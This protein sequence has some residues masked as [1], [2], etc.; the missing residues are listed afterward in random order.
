MIQEIQSPDLVWAYHLSAWPLSLVHGS[1][2]MKPYGF[3]PKNEEAKQYIRSVL[4]SLGVYTP[5]DAKDQLYQW[6]QGKGINHTFQQTVRIID[7]MTK[8]TFDA[9]V[10][11]L[12]TQKERIRYQLAWRYK[13]YTRQ[14]GILAYDIAHAILTIRLCTLIGFFRPEE[15]DLRIRDFSYWAE[16]HFDSWESFHENYSL[17]YQFAHAYL[18]VQNDTTTF[19]NL[20]YHYHLIDSYNAFQSDTFL[21]TLWPQ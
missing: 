20:M 14:S 21:N 4:G 18:I 19:S 6:A 11:S 16:K 8:L 9:Y 3:D 17:G 7:T 1:D 2:I 13:A 15:A 12:K 5:K 10:D